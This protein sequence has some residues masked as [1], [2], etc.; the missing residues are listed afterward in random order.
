MEMHRLVASFL[1]FLAVA[2]CRKTYGY[3]RRPWPP[4]R[5]MPAAECGQEQPNCAACLTMNGCSWCADEGEPPNGG[6]CKLQENCLTPRAACEPIDDSVASEEK[7]EPIPA[8]SE[9]PTAAEI[10]NVTKNASVLCAEFG[11]GEG[12]C[13][14]CVRHD[15]CFWCEMTSSC[16][17]YFNETTSRQSCPAGNWFKEQCIFP[18]MRRTFSMFSYCY[19]RVISTGIPRVFHMLVLSLG[20]YVFHYLSFCEPSGAT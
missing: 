7:R 10:Q 19:G 2:E 13:G 14:A 9:A 1:L 12:G 16:H 8:A 3:H 11:R 5:E 20:M 6:E 17:S 18:G 4:V 15:F